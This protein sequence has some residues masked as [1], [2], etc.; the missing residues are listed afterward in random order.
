MS[1]FIPGERSFN[2]RCFATV[3]RYDL[4]PIPMVGGQTLGRR[5]GGPLALVSCNLNKSI[6]Q[7]TGGFTLGVKEGSLDLKEEILAGDWV[8]IHMTRN[9]Q[10]LP[11]MLG[12]ITDVQRTRVSRDGLTVEDWTI[13][14]RDFAHIFELTKVWFDDFTNYQTN[15]GG[16]IL[17]QRM[18]FNPGGH[19]DQIVTN[20][21]MAWLGAGDSPRGL[22]GGTWVWPQ[23]LKGLGEFFADGLHLSVN[24]APPVPIGVLDEEPHLRGESFGEAA[25]FSPKESTVLQDLLAEW[26]NPVLNELFYDIFADGTNGSSPEDPIPCVYHRERPFINASEGTDSPWFK[27]PKWV[28]PEDAPVSSNIA[29]SSDMERLN[30]FMLYAVGTGMI[31]MD[32]Y[33]VYPPSY[34]RESMARFGLRKWE[35]STRYNTVANGQGN[36]PSELSQW[37]RLLTSWYAPNHYWLSGSLELP[38]AMPEARIGQRL[39]VGEGEDKET[40]YIENVSVGWRF[41]K[42]A[43]TTFGLTRGYRGDDGDIVDFVTELADRYV[44]RTVAGVPGLEGVST[45]SL[46]AFAL[47]TEKASKPVK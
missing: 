44:R 26:S 46:R 42:R 45:A 5:Q 6:G 29:Q 12:R 30:L 13:Q 14:G 2:T 8:V 3:H 25:L 11:G 17:G 9:G 10:K 38:Y 43:S 39:Q 21:I 22:L 40:F 47:A 41:T 15:A 1:G 19:P 16:Q 27:L 31:N 33:V 18:N 23:S 37:H 35:Q 7:A 36:W 32:Q 34:D 24:G 28:I 20:I 4:G